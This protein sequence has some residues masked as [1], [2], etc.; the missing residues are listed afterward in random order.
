VVARRHRSRLVER[1]FART[2]RRQGLHV[3]PERRS[4]LHAA[5]ALRRG[6]WVALM[7][8]R[9]ADADAHRRGPAVCAWAAALA[10]RTGAWVLPG[11]MLRLPSGELAACFEAPLTPE[12]LAAGRHREALSRLLSRAPDQW[13]GF[14]P[15]PE[16]LAG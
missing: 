13:F 9:G 1:A 10:R 6:E 2:R 7:A 3:L 5:A 15:L 12:R 14:E 4:W 8:D 11:V 16:E